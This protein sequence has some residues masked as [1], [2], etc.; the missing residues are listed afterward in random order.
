MLN[1]IKNENFNV[2]NK[3]KYAQ[4]YLNSPLSQES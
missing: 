1:E 2:G 4:N 3:K